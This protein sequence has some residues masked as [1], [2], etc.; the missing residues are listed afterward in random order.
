[1][2]QQNTSTPT[3]KSKV[4]FNEQM[5]AT[6]TSIL[7][8]KNILP[9]KSCLREIPVIYKTTSA[10][11]P[12]VQIE[13]QTDMTTPLL[14]PTVVK[15]DNC[16][17]DKN[18]DIDILQQFSN[19]LTIYC[20]NTEP[21]PLSTIYPEFSECI[22]MEEVISTSTILAPC[23]FDIKKAQAAH[24]LA[25][26]DLDSKILAADLEYTN[27]HGL[28]ATLQKSFDRAAVTTLQ[29]AVINEKFQ[30]VSTF[31]HLEQLANFGVDTFRHESFRANNGIGCPTYPPEIA[32]ME[33]ILDHLAKGHQ[34]GHFLILPLDIVKK[35]AAQE[36]L[37]LHVS[38]HF[39]TSKLDDD[40][41]RLVTNFSHDG[42]NHP[43]KK[44]TL[45][46]I[47]GNISPPQL[48]S[49][50]QLV[51]NAHRLF[52]SE[53]CH[54]EGSRRDI[55]KAFYR[56]RYSPKSSLLCASQV[57]YN[58]TLYA[59]LPSVALMGD[60]VV[61]SCFHQV[62]T[63]IKEKL[64]SFIFEFTG[65]DIS[66]ST[67]ATDDIIMVGTPALLDAGTDE[68][69][70]LVG[71]GR[72]P[73]LCSSLSAINIEKDL[74]GSSV[75]F[76]GWRFHNPDRVVRPNART[77]AKL[78]YCLFVLVGTDPKP[79][80]PILVGTLMKISAHVIRASNIL[81]PMLPF[82]RSFSRNLKGFTN[83]SDIV[84]LNNRTC[85]DLIFWRVFLTMA[86]YDSRVLM[87]KTHVPLLSMNLP[88]DSLI[89]SRTTRSIQQANLVAYSDA[90]TGSLSLSLTPGLGG[91]IP[92]YGYFGQRFPELQYILLGNG[93]IDTTSINIL[94]LLALIITATLTIQL[95]IQHHGTAR[96]CHFHIYCD[97]STAI[98][99]ARTHRSNHPIYTYLLYLF[100]YI[101]LQ[102]GCTVG[103]SFHPGRL[104]VV[105]D[106]TTRDFQVPNG[107]EI[108]NKYLKHLPYYQPSQ[109][110]ISGIHR[111]L[112]HS[113]YN[114]L[115]QP[116]PQ[117]IKLVQNISPSFFH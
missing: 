31:K 71:D 113:Q 93:K 75:D 101:Q 109:E 48:G 66:L 24:R 37:T 42:P 64:G 26:G 58:S 17:D 103:T 90:C 84:Y 63:A 111:V 82:S 99:K 76:L 59:V 40:T 98:S 73:G 110:C 43:D 74:R 54:L 81:R 22:S 45:A 12:L 4:Q 32:D 116:V 53:I 36:N 55:A 6:T 104:N 52:P 46:Q 47:Y 115:Q 8:Q 3:F 77:V 38:P 80:Q 114:V 61:N 117:P 88:S 35:C 9:G 29:P 107:F 67:V 27:Q 106:A 56:L 44:Q 95:Y 23:K 50:C 89:E 112:Q 33:I 41:G 13:K 87:S 86:F 92:G 79:G 65:S 30:S 72:A 57:I 108:Y 60:Q 18:S 10:C 19:T 96:G 21:I 51:E 94:E 97:N 34:N 49:I 25:P 69:G 62:T 78:V 91:Y 2:K 105:A 85:T 68:I 11:T 20:D 83:V 100:S 14:V 102:N 16:V 5:G 15:R 70:R 1:M 39:L 7:V 28:Y